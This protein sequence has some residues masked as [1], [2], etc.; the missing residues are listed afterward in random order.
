MHEQTSPNKLHEKM[1]RVISANEEVADAASV[2]QDPPDDCKE[3]LWWGIS[4]YATKNGELTIEVRDQPLGA[5]RVYDQIVVIG[6]K[7]VEEFYPVKRRYYR[8]SFLNES[9][10]TLNLD[11]STHKKNG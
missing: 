6:T 3:Y 7:F 10:E 4:C 1:M 2:V 9:G 11:L 8:V 5:W